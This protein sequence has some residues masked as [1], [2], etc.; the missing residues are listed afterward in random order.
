MATEFGVNLIFKAQT[1]A[2]DQAY[3]KL[4][5]FERTA[6]KLKGADPF[7]GAEASARDAGRELEKLNGRL[8][9]SQGRF[10]AAGNEAER[11]GRTI[12]GS[13]GGAVGAISQLAGAYLTARAAQ[14]AFAA[15]IERIESGRRLTAL[16]GAFGEVEAAQNAAARAA[17]RFGIGQTEANQSF[18]QI[19]AR[20][21]P[22]GTSLKDIET[23]YN[24][25]NTAAKL[26]GTNASEASSAWMQ[27]S[28]ALGSGVLRGEELNSVFEQTPG[29]V[30]AIAKEMGAPI[31]QI[32]QLAQDGKITS[33]IVIRALRRIETEGTD[34]LTEA[35]NGP[36]QKIKNFQNAFENTQVAVTEK[37]VPELTRS[38]EGLSKLIVNLEGPIRFIGGLAANT[39]GTINDLIDAATKPKA[40][41]AEQAIRGGRLPL[42]GLGGIS[43]AGELFAG[44]SGSGG[45]GLTGLM[46]E[47]K[48]LAALRRQP[49]Q[50]V[51]LEL[52][53]NRLKGMDAKNSPSAVIAAPTATTALT[54][55]TKPK[56]EL[57][58][59]GKIEEAVRR[60]VIGGMTG[61]G[62]SDASRGSSS[63]PH[64]HAQLRS[65]ANLERMVDQ[66]LDFG[67]GR[68]ASSFGLG[69]GAGPRGPNG[70]GYAGRDY[71]TPQGS[72]FTLKPGWTAKDMGIQGDLGRGI[73]VSGPGGIFELGHLAGVKTGALNGKGAAGDMLDAQQDA[74]NAID[75]AERK[76]A[77]DLARSVESGTKLTLDLTRQVELM[78]AGSNHARKLLQIEHEYEDRKA[79]INELMDAGQKKEL[80]ALNDK[81]R[82]LEIS[83][84]EVAVLYEKLGVQDLLGKSYGKGGG[85]SNFRTDIDLNPNQ[86]KIATYMSEL[87]TQ[88]ANTEGMIISLAGTIEGE[89]GSA[90][91]N[92]ITGLIQGTMTAQ[93]AFSQMFKNIGAAFIEMSTQMI[94]KALVMKVLGILGG[95]ISGGGGIG[96]SN[97]SGAFGGG[98]SVGFNPA[99]FGGGLSFAGGGYTGSGARSGGVDG[100]GGFP[101][102]LHPQETVIDHTQDALAQA[103][104]ALSGRG[105][106]SETSVF[107][108]NKDALTAISRNIE[109]RVIEVSQNNLAPVMVEY[110]GPT[111]SFN[112]DDYLP[113]DAAVAIIEE[114]SQRGAR[115]GQQRTMGLLKN[116]PAARRTIGI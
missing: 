26:A 42:A 86:G 80:T 4:T 64:L 25:F 106:E 92:A 12:K 10:V 17:Q 90:M 19:Y 34:K 35:L 72:A 107:N 36:A 7:Q 65:G 70:H 87:Q 101:A 95:G 14:S 59:K 49:V 113:K 29:I 38:L 6:N 96:A 91:S 73:R 58:N 63:G 82:S 108:E 112:G 53:K 102:I 60:G 5:T 55:A 43:G 31:G 56:V 94:A 28:Q 37:I 66:A 105:A 116:N 68:T 48:E 57:K 77:G 20:L 21:R 13:F 81:I 100:Q 15:G 51:L 61:G 104:K 110:R 54:D 88:L 24:G 89:I 97:F 8:R 69:R 30:Q 3:N 11:A 45:V 79:Q 109:T 85:S 111:L 99:A 78:Q 27:L 23:A 83:K 52:M 46:K 62:Q 50:T 103:R 18:S 114:A 44:T 33:D 41:A 32:R 71:Y 93:E 76:R 84:E 67:G 40:Y 115:L 2:L 16:A 1:Q 9:D 47:A 22:I 74:L 39:F 75:E 98:S